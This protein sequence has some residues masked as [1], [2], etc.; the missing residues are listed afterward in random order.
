MNVDEKISFRETTLR[1]CSSLNIV[2]ALKRCFEYV[3]AFS[4]ANGMTLYIPDPDLNLLKFVASVGLN[5]VDERIL[6]LPEKGR[7]K[8]AAAY[9]FVNDLM[10]G[11]G[12]AKPWDPPDA[13]S[14]YS[15]VDAELDT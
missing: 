11:T 12:A 5:Q 14:H 13:Q 15:E 7:D 2:T 10:V 9:L 3:R 8:R 1:I 4:P 6:P